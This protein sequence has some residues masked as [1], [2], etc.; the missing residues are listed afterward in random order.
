MPQSGITKYH[1]TA[2]SRAATW[3]AYSN[4]SILANRLQIFLRTLGYE[5][6][7]EYCG[8][9]NIGFGV[10]SGNGELG[11]TNY[12]VN[13]W[14]GALI[15]KSEI[16]LTDLPLAPTK[17]IDAGI[18][19]FCKTC[20]KCAEACPSG[21][22]SLEDEPFWDIITEQNNY[23]QKAYHINWHKCR[24]Y[25]WPPSIYSVGGCSVCQ[26]VCVFSKLDK[27]S[28]HDL[29]KPIV[30][31]TNLFNGFFKAMD[32]AF[33]YNDLTNPEDFWNRDFKTYPYDFVA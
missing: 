22:L 32:D 5:G 21:A 12:L 9:N 2:L 33:S 7:G 17:P 20:K 29:V 25:A 23:G 14:N 4:S 16:M 13:P 8:V 15:R 30:A 3:G 1:N 27:S 26:G 31:K 11:R 28:V 6:L 18:F 24:P 19:R 10:L